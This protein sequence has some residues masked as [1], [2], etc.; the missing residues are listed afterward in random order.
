MLSG[1]QVNVTP[2]RLNLNLDRPNYR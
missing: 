1:G 2:A